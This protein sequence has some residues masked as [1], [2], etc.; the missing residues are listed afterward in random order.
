MINMASCCSLC[1]N[2]WNCMHYSCWMKMNEWDA[3]DRSWSYRWGVWMDW[4]VHTNK[5][6]RVRFPGL[7]GIVMLTW[8]E[9]Q[10]GSIRRWGCACIC[11]GACG[12]EGSQGVSLWEMPNLRYDRGGPCEGV[13]I[14]FC[15]SKFSIQM[16]Y[17]QAQNGSRV[18]AQLHQ[19]YFRSH[20]VLHCSLWDPQVQL[21]WYIVD[22]TL[23]YLMELQISMSY[24]CVA[25]ILN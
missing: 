22:K 9:L 10:T 14:C 21:G 8:V 7:T 24:S 3:G 20:L 19:Y 2:V 15:L 18:S 13:K 1:T 12:S 25:N 5:G 16:L 6:T 4:L 17:I 23:A 11:E